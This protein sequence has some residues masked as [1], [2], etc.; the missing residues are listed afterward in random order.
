MR[1]VFLGPESLPMNYALCCRLVALFLSASFSIAS[2]AGPTEDADAAFKSG[3]YATA[4]RLWRDL[5]QQGDASAQ[6]H[7]GVMY[8][9][10]RGVPENHAEAVQ[11]FRKA[12]EQGDALGQA[13]LG[14]GYLLI[15]T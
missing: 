7:L 10:G 4:L 6:G 14:V 1:F 8:G 11:W 13:Y 3:D 2:A 9:D 15:F 12:A 5:A